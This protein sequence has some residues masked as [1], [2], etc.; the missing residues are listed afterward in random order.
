ML[1]GQ[2]WS[3]PMSTVGQVDTLIRLT[4]LGNSGDATE[5]GWVQSV[6]HDPAL[7]ITEKYEDTNMVWQ[8]VDYEPTIYAINFADP[9]VAYF[10]VKLGNIAPGSKDTTIPDTFLFQNRASL[11]W[12]VINLATMAPGYEFD[13]YKV[14]HVTA[15]SAVPEP[16]MMLLLGVGLLGLGIAA[17]RKG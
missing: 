15:I 8:R 6:L 11:A 12:G 3:I 4:N 14:S 5:I 9:N 2:A 13:I 10:L 17:R 7:Q 1:A 16:G